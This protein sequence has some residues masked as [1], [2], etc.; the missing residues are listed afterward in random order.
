[1]KKLILSLA[2]MAFTVC[3]FAQNDFLLVDTFA[4]SIV[5]ARMQNDTIILNRQIKM[6]EVAIAE[7]NR[8]SIYVPDFNFI[9]KISFWEKR[10][11]SLIEHKKTLNLK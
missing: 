11:N 10:L 6:A 8:R 2:F 1:M 9:Q 7:Y 5:G 3:L 4:D